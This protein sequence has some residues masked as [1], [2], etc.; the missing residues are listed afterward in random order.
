[1][2]D[3]V[4]AMTKK[5]DNQQ[6]KLLQQIYRVGNV[7]TSFLRLLGTNCRLG[8]GKC[9]FEK[10]ERLPEGRVGLFCL[11]GARSKLPSTTLRV[12]FT[13]SSSCLLVRHSLC[14]ECYYEIQRNWAQ[15]NRN[16]KLVGPPCPFCRQ[17]IT[18]LMPKFNS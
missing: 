10:E 18:D 12:C 4:E 2:M 7:L 8:R 5:D 14:T 13:S 6:I 16:P 1:M 17:T 11:H 3:L 15:H 9:K